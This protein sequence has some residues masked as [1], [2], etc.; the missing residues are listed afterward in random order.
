[1]TPHLKGPALTMTQPQL[2]VIIVGLTVGLLA[3]APDKG[4]STAEPSAQPTAEETSESA[5]VSAAEG[6]QQQ[7]VEKNRPPSN[8]DSTSDNS[9]A[10]GTEP[11]AGLNAETSPDELATT[12]SENDISCDA[13][14]TQSELNICAR[15]RY[16]QADEQLNLVY[17]ALK[18]DLPDS[19]QQAL[20]SAET[21]WIEFRDRNCTFAKNQFEGGSIAPLIYNSCLETHTNDRVAELQQPLSP[22]TSYPAADAQLND[23]YQ[24]LLAVLSEP[25]IEDITDIQLAWIEYRDRNCTFEVLHSADVIEESQCLARMSEVRTAQLAQDIEQRSL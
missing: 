16:L 24:A 13:L 9:D 5:A 23:T 10:P 21:A 18:R 20:T 14:E 7:T 22:Q 6:E 8:N 12:R 1:M 15:E 11:G 17:Q 3:C 19:S 2:S 4:T 25:E